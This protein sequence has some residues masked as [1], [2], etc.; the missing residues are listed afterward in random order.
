MRTRLTESEQLL[1]L[2]YECFSLTFST[3]SFTK[4]PSS[5]AVPAE[6]RG[7]VNVELKGAKAYRLYLML[8]TIVIFLRPLYI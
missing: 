6:R 1:Y 3:L 5:T 7:H 2:D 4:M 8:F